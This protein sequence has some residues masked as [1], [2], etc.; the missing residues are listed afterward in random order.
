MF[1]HYRLLEQVGAGGM[2]V[3][4]RARDQQ[5]QRDVAVKVLPPGVFSDP[6][7]R[8]RFR[9]EALAVGRLNH[10][11]IAMAFDFG[12]QDGGDYLVT[13]YISGAGLDER[14]GKRPLPPKEV[15]ELGSQMMSGLEAAHR[16]GVIHRDLKP[17]NIRLD[18]DGQLKILDFGL[19]KVNAARDASAET[20]SLETSLSAGGT[21]PYMPPEQL[22]GEPVDVRADIWSAGA[23]L[24]EMATGTRAFPDRQPSL[25][26]D[27]ILHHD[28]VR[29]MLLNPQVTPA[30]ETVIL[31]AL[32]R[33]PER[34]YQSAR[35]LRVDLARLLSGSDLGLDRQPSSAD[36]AA[37]QGPHFFRLSAR[38]RRWFTVVFAVLLIMV[39]GGAVVWRNL[40]AGSRA[41]PIHSIAVLPFTDFSPGGGDEYFAD[42]M[43]EELISQLTQV[44][45]LRVISRSSVMQY[46]GR[47]PSPAVVA[48]ELK[49]EGVIEGTIRREENRVRITVA[50]ADARG[51]RNLWSRSYERDLGDVLRLQAEVARAIVEGVKVE[52]TPQEAQ[53]LAAAPSTIAPQVYEAY[54]QG[55]YYLN[56]RTAASLRTAVAKFESVTAADPNYARA[57]VGLADAYALLG[58]YRAL[59]ARR[60]LQSAKAAAERAIEL[61]ARSGEAHASL[62]LIHWLDLEWASAD[63]DFKIALHLNPGYATAHH[64]YALYLAAQG[65]SA[66]A[67][68]EIGVAEALD[69]SS[70]IIQTNTAWCY[71]LARKYDQAIRQAKQVLAHDPGFVVAHEY[72]GQSYVEKGQFDIAITELSTAVQLSGG[73]PYYIAELA[74]AYASAGQTAEAKSL[75]RELEAEGASA[76]VSTADLALVYAGLHDVSR[77]T[78]LLELAVRE[79]IPMVVNLKVH[80]RYD[81]LRS[82]PRFAALLERLGREPAAGAGT[83]ELRTKEFS[84]LASSALA[85]TP[86]R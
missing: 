17:G 44:A 39:A 49:V 38:G 2:G 29:P 22:K 9:K 18:R 61:D 78:E 27:A 48:R 11:N 83:S 58:L 32:D 75:L 36:Q 40:A 4:F 70:S 20:A 55:R 54:L 43:T 81:V 42:G 14:I 85:P 60:A 45:A 21:L 68:K 7:R 62:G 73:V 30:L 66:Q 69:P 35:E 57:Y 28:P 64:W 80:P 71:Y 67:L 15:L 86:A 25:V 33:D 10:P 5:L 34:R 6:V 50:L 65:D 13:E 76:N 82:D 52:T 12:E 1:G 46:R 41:G 79:R 63:E 8:E 47:Q 19:A 24:Y 59:P 56:Q 53:Q 51:G 23:V 16:E 77:A 3:V 37:P 74:N 26:I 72:L 31:K 84:G